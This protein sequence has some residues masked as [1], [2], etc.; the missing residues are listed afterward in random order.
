MRNCLSLLA[1]MHKSV[2]RILTLSKVVRL[3][4][5]LK[6]Y[7]GGSAARTRCVRRRSLRERKRLDENTDFPRRQ[8]VRR[9]S[10]SLAHP[11]H[12]RISLTCSAHGARLKER[13][14]LVLNRVVSPRAAPQKTR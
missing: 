1:Q 13:R 4:R 5:A 6:F 12:G 10:Q 9:S 3:R 14:N 11:S 7:P 8:T 2:S